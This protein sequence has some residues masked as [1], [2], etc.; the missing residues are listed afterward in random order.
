MPHL[1]T[2]ESIKV[3]LKKVF[4]KYLENCGYSV[5]RLSEYS[6]PFYFYFNDDQFIES[7]GATITPLSIHYFKEL[8]A[9]DLM[10]K[11]DH[12]F[13]LTFKGYS[14]AYRIKHPLKYFWKIH[15]QWGVATGIAILGLISTAIYSYVS[16]C[17]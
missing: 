2:D 4:E 15:W 8:V 12:G 3:F 9:R 11:S 17:I 14:E 5:Q 7:N 1:M 13:C 10:I 6:F 16:S